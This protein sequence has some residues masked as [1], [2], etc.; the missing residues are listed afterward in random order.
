V[1]IGN[2]AYEVRSLKLGLL[3]GKIFE[4]G[5]PSLREI[6]VDTKFKQLMVLWEV[7]IDDKQSYK[8]QIITLCGQNK[9][10]F[11]PEAGG[12]YSNRRVIRHFQKTS[13]SNGLTFGQ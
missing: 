4:Y 2:S 3:C 5:V 1:K 13:M 11:N 9:C 12:T 10:F 7:V 6:K 8:M